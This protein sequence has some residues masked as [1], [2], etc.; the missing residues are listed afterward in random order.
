[1]PPRPGLALCH[2]H[3]ARQGNSL[4]IHTAVLPVF[5]VIARAQHLA[6]VR[7]LQDVVAAVGEQ[8]GLRVLSLVVGCSSGRHHAW[9]KYLPTNWVVRW[10][11]QQLGVQCK[12]L[13]RGKTAMSSAI[14][15]GLF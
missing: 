14:A 15:L 8:N 4:I 1:M 9:W 7:V 2:V 12:A 11:V 3:L 13:R 10:A 5:R 6:D